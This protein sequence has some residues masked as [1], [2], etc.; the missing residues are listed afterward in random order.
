MITA[1]SFFSLLEY[2]IS[3]LL[4]PSKVQLHFVAVLPDK[5]NAMINTLRGN[6]QALPTP[7][8]LAK[9]LSLC[10][11]QSL[12]TVA[13]SLEPM[14]FTEYTLQG[15]K[16]ASPESSPAEPEDSC[17]D[18]FRS[19]C[20]WWKW[21]E[22]QK[23]VN[24]ALRKV[25]PYCSFLVDLSHSL[26]TLLAHQHCYLVHLDNLQLSL[27]ADGN[28]CVGA[29]LRIAKLQHNLSTMLRISLCM[30]TSPNAVV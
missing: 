16:T 14:E 25:S 17:L 11:W 8:Y 20:K 7:A 26:A 6:S 5:H 23:K 22:E 1:V 18:S 10:A 28:C 15:V 2:Q 13:V 12:K 30:T 24:P 3:C 29:S 4:R 9:F 19:L 21:C 27:Q